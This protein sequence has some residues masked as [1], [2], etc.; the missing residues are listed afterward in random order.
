MICNLVLNNVIN[1]VKICCDK[2]LQLELFPDNEF[3][4]PPLC[5][6]KQTQG[7]VV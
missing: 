3:T 5:I 1:N 2:A 4:Q 6:A 7:S